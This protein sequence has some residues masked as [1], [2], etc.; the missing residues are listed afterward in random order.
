M[1]SLA[2]GWGLS[3]GQLARRYSLM[4]PATAFRRLIRAAGS[5]RNVG[6]VQRSKLLAALV[7]A[8]LVEVAGVAV[9]D[10]LGVTAVE[11]Q[12]PVGAL[13]GYRTYEALGVRVAV[14][15][16]RGNLCHG[17][18]F[19][20]EGGV[21]G[22][23]EFRVPVADEVGEVGGVLSEVPEQ[24]GACWVAQAAVMPRM[25]TVRVRTSITNRA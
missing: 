5:S 15:A 2:V 20:G 25:W 18:A 14:G 21:E 9:E 1:G 13:L 16:T 19:A 11:Q 12:D 17:D 10:P 24:L 23:G 6:V 22:G 8:M 4:R 3:L 7:G